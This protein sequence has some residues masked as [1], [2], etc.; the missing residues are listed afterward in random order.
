MIEIRRTLVRNDSSPEPDRR[1]VGSGA[2]KMRAAADLILHKNCMEIAEILSQSSKEGRIQS[3]KLLYDLADENRRLGADETREHF[4]TLASELEAEPQWCE[5][6]SEE[7]AET[8]GG[9]REPEN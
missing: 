7:T 9:G 4:H 8:A 1:K 6:A 2:E 5:E 3:W